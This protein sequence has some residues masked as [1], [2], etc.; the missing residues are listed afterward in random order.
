MRWKRSTPWKKGTL[1]KKSTP[2]KKSIP[3]MKRIPKKRWALAL[4]ICG[5]LTLLTAV[6]AKTSL[7]DKAA[8]IMA[9]LGSMCFALGM[10]HFLIGRFEERH[11]EQHRLNEIEAKDERNTA[12]RCRARAGAGT[13]L[14]WT[15]M[16]I[17]WISILA[18][19]PM[20]VI[21]ALVGAFGA[22]ALLEFALAQYYSRRM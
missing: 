14:Q 4:G 19:G 22:K 20:W 18:D 21:L 17:V 6:L 15:V 11:P 13:F 16:G 1:W 2:W 7:P 5:I 9:G 8:G 3:W 12:I 10:V